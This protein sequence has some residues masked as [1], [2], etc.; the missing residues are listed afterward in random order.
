VVTG[1][2]GQ[3]FG[4]GFKGRRHATAYRGEQRLQR[5]E[6]FL[7]I[8]VDRRQGFFARKLT[9]LTRLTP[10]GRYGLEFRQHTGRDQQLIGFAVQLVGVTEYVFF[11]QLEHDQFDA[12]LHAQAHHSFTVQRQSLLAHLPS[13]AR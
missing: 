13:F 1:G 12:D 5:S 8:F 10:A 11:K 7:A 9:G 6:G 3:G 2:D 4:A